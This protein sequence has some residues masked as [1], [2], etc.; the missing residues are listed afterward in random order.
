ML[1]YEAC[2]ATN[3]FALDFFNSVYSH[4]LPDH[5]STEFHNYLPRS[6]RAHASYKFADEAF[7]GVWI[8]QGA[9]FP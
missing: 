9:T 7:S 2:H 1:I 4:L 5:S 3:I 8:S 6:F